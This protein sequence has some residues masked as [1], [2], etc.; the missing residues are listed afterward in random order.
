MGPAGWV[1]MRMEEAASAGLG[2]ED[3][4]SECS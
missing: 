2:V 1:S 3:S 4:Y